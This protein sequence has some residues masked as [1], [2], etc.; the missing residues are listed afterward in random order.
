MA[1]D[2]ES[3][4]P[5]AGR[6]TEQSMG[7][8]VPSHDQ[9]EMEKRLRSQLD[10]IFEDDHDVDT[11][12]DVHI[13]AVKWWT[14]PQPTLERREVANPPTVTAQ[15]Q[16]TSNGTCETSQ[17]SPGFESVFDRVFEN[18]ESFE[19]KEIEEQLALLGLNTKDPCKSDFNDAIHA[20]SLHGEVRKAEALLSQMISLG[21]K[22]SRVTYACVINSCAQAGNMVRAEDWLREMMKAGV[23]PNEHSYNAVIH[24]CAK[25]GY[26]DRAEEWL[27]A[28]LDKDATFKPNLVS[29]NTVINAHARAGNVERAE[30]WLMRMV[31]AEVMPNEVSFGSVINACAEA[32]NI[33]KAERWLKVMSQD[34]WLQPNEF[35]Y[36]AVIKAC[37]IAGRIER[38]ETWM[39]RMKEAGFN[40]TPVTYNLVIH[41]CAQAGNVSRGEFFLGEMAQNGCTANKITYN[42]VINAC[43]TK[44]EA[45]RAEYWLQQMSVQGV[46]PDH[47][48]YGALC[49]AHSREGNYLQVQRI[50][51]SLPAKGITPNEYFYASLISACACARPPRA[52][53]AEQAFIECLQQGLSAA[54]VMR[55][56]RRALGR[57]RAVQ[58]CQELQVAWEDKPNGKEKLHSQSKLHKHP[59]ESW[60]SRQVGAASD[61]RTG[62]RQ[63]GGRLPGEGHGRTNKHGNAGSNKHKFANRPCKPAPEPPCGVHL[64]FP[65]HHLGTTGV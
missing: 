8:M 41:A 18:V 48:T 58:L 20:H 55:V 47:V 14:S 44:G 62:N 3:N 34:S 49:K 31:E 45:R 64:L 60:P 28:L 16:P 9:D 65:T 59:L 19:S 36:N 4:S 43:A 37:V 26:A 23:T 61:C 51:D 27:Q 6:Y 5:A 52:R 24:A 42:T 46:E 30:H 2:V 1:P 63:S 25:A 53:V 33:A 10:F 35:S 38:A 56:L 39:R 50:I 21:H 29:Y 17:K 11:T 12:P 54:P 40:M 7:N 15:E 57:Q 32:G 13:P 22:P